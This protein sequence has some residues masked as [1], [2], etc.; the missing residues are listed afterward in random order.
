MTENKI[1]LDIN[2]CSL[3]KVNKVKY[4]VNAWFIN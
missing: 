4:I 1:H 2:K 3:N